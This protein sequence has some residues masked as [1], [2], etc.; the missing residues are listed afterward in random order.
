MPLSDTS[1]T[2][3]FLSSGQCSSS[4][5][6]SLSTPSIPGIPPARRD[7]L[8][9]SRTSSTCKRQSPPSLSNSSRQLSAISRQPP[10]KRQSLSSLPCKT[11]PRSA[12]SHQIPSPSPS[13]PPAPLPSLS[14]PSEP[15]P[16][17]SQPPEP[18]PSLSQ[19]LNHL[20]LYRS[21]L[22]HLCYHKDITS[23]KVTRSTP[24]AVSDAIPCLSDVCELR[25]ST[26]RF[27]PTKAKP[28]FARA[29]SSALRAVV[30]DN[31]VE[32]WSTLFLSPKCV[33]PSS[34]CGGR[35]NKPVPVG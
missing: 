18:P 14:Q 3:A 22:N 20:H 6:P 23:L 29:L 28:A 33:L 21:L 25:C 10:S 24:D 34:K 4:S 13:Q 16:S 30:S 12:F 19:P 32:S 11:Q 26:I 17:L 27:I 15:P 7:L 31:S 8:S 5:S 35:H 1:T 2:V 9:T